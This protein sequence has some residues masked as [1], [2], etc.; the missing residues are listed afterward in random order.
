MSNTSYAQF[1][2]LFGEGEVGQPPL[3]NEGL[4]R[5]ETSTS[6]EV[7]IYNDI[8]PEEQQCLTIRISP[9]NVAGKNKREMFSCNEQGPSYFCEHT[10]CI[11]DDDGKLVKAASI[12]H[13]HFTCRNGYWVLTSYVYSS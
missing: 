9:V 12:P 11:E 5:G 10:I 8:I 3:L 2:A 6:F 1:D 13:I 7:L 4:S